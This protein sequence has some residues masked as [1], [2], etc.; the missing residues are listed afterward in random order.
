MPHIRECSPLSNSASKFLIKHET[1]VECTQYTLLDAALYHVQKEQV[2][3][4]YHA[5]DAQ[6]PTSE[7]IDRS[8]TGIQT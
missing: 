3:L 4:D 2:W 8:A 6:F 7:I 5:R 1:Q